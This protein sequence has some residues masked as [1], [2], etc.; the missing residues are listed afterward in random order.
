MIS[1]DYEANTAIVD[2][3]PDAD[4]VETIKV[5]PSLLADYDV[6]GQLVSVEI[7]SIKALSRPDVINVLRRLLGD[8]TPF[9]TWQY[10][11]S[12]SNNIRLRD[13]AIT[14]AG[15]REYQPLGR[16]SSPLP[17]GNVPDLVLA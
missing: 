3:R 10:R 1:I 4:S 16:A 15:T 2:L 7:L 12:S 14:T 11:V 9:L 8:L 5:G 17:A 6:R 13:L